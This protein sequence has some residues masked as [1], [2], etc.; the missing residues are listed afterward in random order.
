[1]LEAVA[2]TVPPGCLGLMLV[3]Y[4]H[5]VLNPYWDPSAAG[6]TI[7][8]TGEHG[9]EHFYRAVLE[10][11]A[12]E[13]RLAG[14]GLVAALGRRSSESRE[15][16]AAKAPEYAA[17]GGGS[18]SDL[19]C[20]IIADV[21]GIALVRGEPEATCLGAGIMAA[22]AAGMHHGIVEAARAMTRTFA[23]FEPGSEAHAFYNEL[24]DG[25]YRHIFPTLRSLLHRLTQL[26]QDR[27]AD[28][29]A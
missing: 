10:G 23:R 2:A 3:P 11:V 19:W 9:R 8:W 15:K 29:S 5:N 24:Y 25:V 21:T 13:Q 17:I 12:F 20:R 6:V 28:P 22:A 16:S 26:A 1:M 4:W 18:R 14:E 7:G 27:H